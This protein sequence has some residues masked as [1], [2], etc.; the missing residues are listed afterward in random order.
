[1]PM[2]SARRPDSGVAEDPLAERGAIGDPGAEEVRCP[3]DGDMDPT[4]V[5]G[6]EQLPG[7]GC[8]GAA[9]DGRCHKREV[10]GHGYAAGRAVAVEVLQADQQCSV[11]LG[12]GQDATLERR[13]QLGPFGVRGVQALVD[14]R[15]A[16]CRLGRGYSIAG[17][18]SPPFDSFGQR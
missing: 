16:A 3:A 8:P 14:D 4:G 5:P 7:H 2:K 11:P 18:G 1:M 6:L 10:L 9:L 15:G 17:V 12:C 13:E